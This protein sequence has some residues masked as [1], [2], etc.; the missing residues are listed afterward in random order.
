MRID[1]VSIFPEYLAG[2]LS[3]SLLGK[4]V[5]SGLLEVRLQILAYVERD[6]FQLSFVAMPS[7]VK[8]VRKRPASSS[9]GFLTC[10]PTLTRCRY[11]Q[12]PGFDGPAPSVPP[13]SSSTVRGSA[14]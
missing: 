1:V 14:A 6:Q 10:H 4:A 2:P 12:S 8:L 11:C 5:S 7:S 13:T 9:T 3:V